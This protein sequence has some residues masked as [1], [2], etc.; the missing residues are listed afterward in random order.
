[1]RRPHRL[2]CALLGFLA[3]AGG[4]AAAPLPAPDGFSAAIA[5][6]EACRYSEARTAFQRLA[7]LQPESPELD[8][9]LGRLA[10]WFDDGPEA[11]HYLERAA[12]CAPAEAR[13]QN[14]LGDAY[15]LAAQQANLLAKLGWARR[16]LAAYERAVE[17]DPKNP[18]F[19]WSLV[20][21]FCIAPSI[22]GGGRDKAFAQA[23][24]LR[25]LDPM[26]GRVA[27]ATLYLAQGNPTAAFA[28]FDE[29]LRER[30]DDFLALYHVGRCAALSG[31][32]LERGLQVLRRCLTLTPPAGEG[33]PTLAAV[34]HRLGN[35][36]EKMGDPAAAAAEYQAAERE[37]PDFRPAK[38]ALKN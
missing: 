3:C 34:R 9:Y 18:A 38:M 12:G 7:A 10:L 16:C 28:Q 8:F 6:Y 1:M 22:A 32:Q 25:R 17:L 37:N 33:M 26:A 30:P 29:V 20:G 23:A 19:R 21:Y 5:L 14:A 35:I 24:E 31:Q 15:G 2:S 27:Y 4:L 36:L 13:I 11:R